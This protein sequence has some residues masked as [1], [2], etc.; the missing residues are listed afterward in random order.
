MLRGKEEAKWVL[1]LQGVVVTMNEVGK[2]GFSF[3]ENGKIFLGYT[4]LKMQHVRSQS[5][6]YVS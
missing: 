2:L 6:T 5:S 4:F 1:R 3:Q